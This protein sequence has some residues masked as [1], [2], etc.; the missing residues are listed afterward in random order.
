MFKRTPFLFF[1][2]LIV[3]TMPLPRAE[4]LGIG[5][6][7]F[8]LD[9]QIDGSNSTTFYITSDGLNGQ[10]IVGKEN[11]PFR[12]KPSR[13]NMTKDDANVPV[14][15]TFYGN[16]TLTPGVYE[17]KVTFLAM[18]GGF[19]AMG[20]KIRAKINL[21]GETIEVQEAEPELESEIESRVEETN[22]TPY[23]IGGVAGGVIAVSLALIVIWWRRR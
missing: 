15:L 21:L 19:V 8:E 1:I 9:L 3:S 23:I 17:G 5:P 20:I 11:L 7:S 14:K 10:L 18:T 4:A 16:E 12:V 2:I 13:I 6:P 22:Y